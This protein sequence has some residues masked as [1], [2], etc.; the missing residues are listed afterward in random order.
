MAHPEGTK[1]K[2]PVR[3]DNGFV[4]GSASFSLAAVL[5][6]TVSVNPGSLAAATSAETD[7]TIT[8]AAVGDIVIMNIPALLENDIAFSGARVKA[9]DTVSIRLSNI[10]NTNAVDGASLSW[11]YIIFRP[12]SV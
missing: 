1:F 10:D 6:G 8:G 4:S 3:S 2:G 7:V 9:A 5:N 11:G 12:T